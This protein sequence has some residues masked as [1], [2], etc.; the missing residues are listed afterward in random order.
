MDLT[1]QEA[2]SSLEV[3]VATTKRDLARAKSKLAEAMA[4]VPYEVDRELSVY[5]EVKG[6]EE[7]LAFAQ[8]VLAER[9]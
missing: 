6:L 1:V 9:F 5:N 2:K 7:G 8:Q 3:T 4:R